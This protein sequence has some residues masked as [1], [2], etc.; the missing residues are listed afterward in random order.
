MRSIHWSCFDLWLDWYVS[1]LELDWY[2]FANRFCDLLSL[3]IW[4]TIWFVYLS[5][6]YIKIWSVYILL[7]VFYISDL[8]FNKIF[9]ELNVG[10]EEGI[11][12]QNRNPKIFIWCPSF[13]SIVSYVI[14]FWGCCAFFIG[15]SFVRIDPS[16]NCVHAML[17]WDVIR[18][19]SHSIK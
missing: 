7:Y 12:D 6:F 3:H 5:F 14:E 2:V 16:H 11:L 10:S 9:L 4:S 17:L 18:T 1:D 15:W 13:C 8:H 19:S